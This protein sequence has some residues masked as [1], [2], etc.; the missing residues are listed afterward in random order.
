M[1]TP[2][3]P[4]E[5]DKGVLLQK[6]ERGSASSNEGKAVSVNASLGRRLLRLLRG[7][8]NGSRNRN[9]HCQCFAFQVCPPENLTK[10]YHRR[11]SY[12]LS[13]ISPRLDAREPDGSVGA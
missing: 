11:A 3:S 5:W 6:V 4:L 13:A 12:Q 1:K 9:Q 7:Q 2:F 10:G 8:R